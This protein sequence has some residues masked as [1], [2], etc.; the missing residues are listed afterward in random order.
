MNKS[1]LIDAV[2][3][4][5]NLSRSDASNAT[6]AVINSIISALGKGDQVNGVRI[7]PTILICVGGRSVLCRRILVPSL[8]AT[9][10]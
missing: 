8:S 3:D 5:A 4:A 7:D 6:D 10:F 9:G 2:A 1:E